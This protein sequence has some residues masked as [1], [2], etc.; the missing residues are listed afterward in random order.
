MQS[1]KAKAREGPCVKESL[2]QRMGVK[3]RFPWL[4][5]PLRELCELGVAERE[6]RR[7]A[8]IHTPAAAEDRIEK[9]R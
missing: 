1:E 9:A 2:A 7:E 6:Y 3:E 4:R 8:G 5:M